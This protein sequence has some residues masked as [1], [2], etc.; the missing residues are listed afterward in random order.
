MG[1]GLVCQNGAVAFVDKAGKAILSEVPGGR[2]MEAAEVQGEQ[3]FH[4]R[5]QWLADA[6][7]AFY[8]LGQH[9]YGLTNIRG[10]DIELWQHNTE[11]AVPLLLSSKGYGIFWENNSYT[12]FGDP[13]PFAAIPA[14]HL[15]D[16]TG[17]AG[18]FTRTSFPMRR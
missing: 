4:V 3:T 13:Q 9:Q 8:G 11:I 15:V 12:K 18:G 1:A 10:Y 16:A 5:Q 17:A 2:T 6:D 14:D 7:E